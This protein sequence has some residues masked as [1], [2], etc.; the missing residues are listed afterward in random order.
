V[1]ILN[2]VTRPSIIFFPASK[3]IRN[4]DFHVP[5]LDD[6][7]MFVHVLH[8]LFHGK[9]LDKRKPSRLSFTMVSF[10]FN[11]PPHKNTCMEGG[12]DL[13][14]GGYMWWGWGYVFLCL[15]S[16]LHFQRERFVE[17]KEIVATMDISE[18]SKSMKMF[19]YVRLCG[20]F[21]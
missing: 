8:R 4:F 9:K 3:T 21:V 11:K 2:L 18:C 5:E 13:W 10:V 19:I 17:G 14:G 6:W 7:E 1:C 20:F 16:R 15:E 12:S